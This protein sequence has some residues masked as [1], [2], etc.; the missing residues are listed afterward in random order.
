MVVDGAAVTGQGSMTGV[1][2]QFI[3]KGEPVVTTHDDAIHAE[4]G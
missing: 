3:V 1:S 4:T 2:G